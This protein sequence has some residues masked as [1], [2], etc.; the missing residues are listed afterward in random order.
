ML[1]GMYFVHFV[2]TG[3]H[4]SIITFTESS[5]RGRAEMRELVLGLISIVHNVMYYL[6]YQVTNPTLPCFTL[7]CSSNIDR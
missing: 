3:M 6:T 2:Y 7:S 1:E 4:P 5:Q